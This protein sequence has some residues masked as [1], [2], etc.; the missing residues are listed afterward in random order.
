MTT[1]YLFQTI[2]AKKQGDRVRRIEVVSNLLQE[3]LQAALLVEDVAFELVEQV[4]LLD[5]LLRHNVRASEQPMKRAVHAGVC[6][7][8]RVHKNTV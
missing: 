5:Y 2:G 7:H 1:A 8:E 3:R 6:A 4:L